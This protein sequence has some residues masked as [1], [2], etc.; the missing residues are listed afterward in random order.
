MKYGTGFDRGLQIVGSL[1]SVISGAVFPIM[2]VFF[3]QIVDNFAEYFQEGSGVTVE[4]FRRR[5]NSLSLIFVYLFL[6][7]FVM[8]Y[9]SMAARISTLIRQAYLR[10]VFKQDL[11]PPTNN[12]GSPGTIAICITT[13]TSL[14]QGGIGEKVGGILQ[15]LAQMICGFAIAFSR[16][17]KL[18]GVCSTVLPAVTLTQ[19][20]CL[21][22]LVKLEHRIVTQDARA[23]DVV[24]E[25]LASIRTTQSLNAHHRAEEQY[26]KIVDIAKGFGVKKAFADACSAGL[27]YFFV[28]A[29]YSLCF[30]YGVRLF[31][32]GSIQNPGVIVTWVY[33]ILQWTCVKLL[34]IFA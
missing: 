30:F 20:L 14:I 6:G 29:S 8:G 34:M 9:I 21:P 5:I 25:V 16:H 11:L 22:A 24:E 2:T 19:I 18:A 23:A 7:K 1:A 17:W 33:N 15:V 3:G 12:N 10:S 27:S 31:R 4:D 26:K 13:I 28:F 32:D